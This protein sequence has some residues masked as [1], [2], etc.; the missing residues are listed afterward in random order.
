[1]SL[2]CEALRY[3]SVACLG[4][5]AGAMLTEGGVLVPYWRSLPP[6]EFLRWYAANAERL[7]GFFGPLTSVTAVLALA[8]A[9]AS[10]WEGHPGR[11]L[12]LTASGLSLVVVATYFVYFHQANTSF[13]TASIGTD[14]VAG[15]LARWRAWHWTRTGLSMV[16][17]AAALLS[18][19]SR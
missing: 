7:L 9:L 12:A 4:V 8:A 19:R 6:V 16:A 5:F 11:W 14:A 10:L 15:E 1:V 13:A 17:F 18:L 2:L 3:L